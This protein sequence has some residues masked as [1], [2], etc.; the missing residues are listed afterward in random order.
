MMG[1]MERIVVTQN[2]SNQGFGQR[3]VVILLSYKA[4]SGIMSVPKPV[5]NT[6]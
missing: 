2:Q 5:F 6:C 4:L 1:F 3:K